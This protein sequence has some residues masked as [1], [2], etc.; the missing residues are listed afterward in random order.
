MPVAPAFNRPWMSESFADFWARRWNLSTT[1]MMRV[2]V[3]EPVMEGRLVAR[4]DA[5]ADPA[6]LSPA[7]AAVAA[8]AAHSAADSPAPA[9]AP[10]AKAL[11]AV[12]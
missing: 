4:L 7:S 9:P 10:V 11:S 5:T 3:Y 1:Y 2:M 8:A 12:A 6:D